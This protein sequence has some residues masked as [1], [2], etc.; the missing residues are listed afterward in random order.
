LFVFLIFFNVRAV[1]YVRVSLEDENPENQK[2]AIESYCRDRGIMLMGVFMDVGVSGGM[3]A[4]ERPG[5]RKMLE[6]CERENVKTIIVYDITR[7]GR[8]C[9]DLVATV[10]TLINRGFYIIFIEDPELSIDPALD[11]V[12]LA[13]RK[14]MF[15]IKAVSS[16][17]ERAF[18]RRRT[19]QALRRAW[20]Q[21]KNIGRPAKTRHVTPQIYEEIVKLCMEGN[22][23]TDIAKRLGISL[24]QVI[25]WVKKYEKETG[26]RLNC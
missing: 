15:M 10:Y 13:R 25:Y 17:L 8:D 9:F 12:E 18:I 22:L 6:F 1:G 16:E 19:K 11:E 24:R 23:K 7:L 20:L 26:K 14:A 5:F 4:L 21:G 2:Y 3:P